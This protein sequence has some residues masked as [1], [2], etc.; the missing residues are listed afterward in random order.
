MRLVA[1]TLLLTKYLMGKIPGIWILRE[2]LLV[3]VPNL[4]SWIKGNVIGAKLQ[5]PLQNVSPVVF[6][7]PKSKPPCTTGKRKMAY[8]SPLPN[9]P[10]GIADYSAELLPELDKYFDIDLYVDCCVKDAWLVKNL[11]IFSWQE[12]S[13]HHEE[14]DAIV[15]QMGNS[16]YHAYMYDL[17]QKYPGIIV[18]HDFF[19][20]GLIFSLSLKDKP[21]LFAQELYYSHGREAY[22]MLQQLNGIEEASKK[23]PCNR[24]V[25]ES[26][27]GTIVHSPFSIEL[28]DKF[29]PERIMAPFHF[30]RHMRRLSSEISEADRNRL[31]A[32]FG[33]SDDEILI[34]SFG[35]LAFTKLNHI[36]LESYL[37]LPDQARAKTRL[38]FIGKLCENDYGYKLLKQ[39]KKHKAKKR[40]IITGYQGKEAYKDYLSIADIA[41]QLRCCS[42]GE[43]SGTVLDCLANGVPVIVNAYATLNDYPDDVVAKI[44]EDAPCSLLKQKLLN[45]IADKKLRKELS[46]RGRAYVAEQHDPK[47]IAAQY[48]L[49]IEEFIS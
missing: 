4:R 1:N 14:Y 45:L 7:R 18:L 41:V 15:Y 12:F 11:K 16:H 31:R 20:S 6:K 46:K 35:F 37:N 25:L 8:F 33:F 21:H 10:S 44:P 36:L 29:Y 32:K 47:K 48:A 2:M 28:K 27:L 40:V 24:R 42:R 13:K 39:I 3:E 43:T 30:I 49:A 34:C 17:L 26:A 9:Q 22:L 19:L 38:I 5:D 23:F